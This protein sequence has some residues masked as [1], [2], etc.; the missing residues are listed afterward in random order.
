VYDL[1]SGLLLSTSKAAVINEPLNNSVMFIKEG[2]FILSGDLWEAVLSFELTPYKD[3][4]TGLNSD[5]H[6]AK[7]VA[8]RT[9]PLVE[10][11]Q[12]KAMLLSL[13]DRLSRIQRYSPKSW[14]KRGLL[15]IGGSVLKSLFGT[16]MVLDLN[17]LHSAVN[18]LD[19]KQDNLTHSLEW[20]LLYF[21][22]LDDPVTFNHQA[23]ANLSSSVKELATKTRDPFPE[24]SS[25]LER[26]TKLR[27]ASSLIRKLV[28]LAP[29]R[30]KYR[31]TD[32]SSADSNN[33]KD[34][35]KPYHSQYP[36]RHNEDHFP[37]ST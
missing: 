31:Q 8:K 2:G 29:A 5:L 20:Q 16:A 28:C 6:I 9:A 21:K 19:R 26:G 25:K 3:A 14:R 22:H 10:L 17:E 24:I 1:V 37:K 12:I 7:E 18:E 36:T 32:A 30:D 11:R 23:T 13:E 15:D 34:T 27:E 35:C 4:V 33:W